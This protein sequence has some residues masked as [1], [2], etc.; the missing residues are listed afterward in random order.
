MQN[1]KQPGKVLTFTAPSG[2][3]ESGDGVQIGQ[4]FVVAAGA[5]GEGQLF[6]GMAEGVFELP[7]VSAQAW[8]EGQLIYWDKAAGLATN[9]AAEDLLLIGCAARAAA[10]PSSVG[11]VRLNGAALPGHAAE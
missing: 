1:F 6:E 9:V 4:I 2:G 7:K 3:V 10:N 11:E 8:T 5:A